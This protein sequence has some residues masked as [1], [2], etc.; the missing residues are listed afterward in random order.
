MTPEQ[1]Q[2]IKETFASIVEQPTER[3]AGLLRELCA[4]DPE[5]W[6]EV[7]S[8]LSAHDDPKSLIVPDAFGIGA[9]LRAEAVDYSGRIFGP[10]RIVRE[11]GR[12]GMGAV[13]L[14]ERAD[15]EFRRQVAL[16]IV[17]HSLAGQEIDRRFRRE[18]Q[19]LAS[20]SHPHIA[21]LLD[22]GVSAD[23]ESFFVM[24]FV[25]GLRID[26]YCARAQLTP[27]ARLKLFLQVCRA[28]AYAHDQ[29]VIHRDLKP[30]NILV[31]KEGVPKLLDFGIAKLLDVS[32]AGEQTA[33]E[34]RAFTPDY[35]APEQMRGEQ[36]LTPAT[37]VFSLGA[38]LAVLLDPSARRR[39]ASAPA[40]PVVP[41]AEPSAGGEGT[42]ETT[43]QAPL[44]RELRN[45]IA[46]AQR[47]EPERRYPSARELSQDIER[48]LDGRPVVAQPDTLRYRISKF[49]EQRRTMLIASVLVL[50]A[51][52]TGITAA[53]F[54]A[55]MNGRRG[56]SP[57]SGDR[58][59][60]G[61][62]GVAHPLGAVRT[63]AV[64]PLK[65][66]AGASPRPAA[67]NGGSGIS[68]GS[69]MDDQALR[70]GMADSIVTK[71]SQVRQLTV[72][73][74]SATVRFLDQEYDAVAVGRELQVDSVLEGTLLRAGAELRTNL[75]LVDVASG[76]VVWAD[77]L[78]SDLSNV[79]RGQESLANRVSQLLALNASGAP[80][81]GAR[82]PQGSAN[83]AAQDAYLR[84]SLALATSV[85]QVANIFAARDAFEQA[86]R[87]DPD[88]ALAHS[89]LANAY[90]LAG[91]LTLLAPQDSYPKA[92]RAARRALEIAPGIAGAYIALA[93]V[94]ADYNWNW[95]AAEEN[96]KK[97]LDLAPNSAGAHQSYAELLA[98]M[99]R[100]AEAAAHADLAQQL[101]PTR[102]NYVAVRALHYYYE[103]RFDEAVAQC[104]RALARD[105]N[106][107]LAYLY[108]AASHAARG[109]FTSG[110]AAANKAQALTGGAASDLFVAGINYALMNDRAN[111][112][113]VLQRL[114]AM[115]HERYIDPFLFVSIYAYRGDK[116]R[117]FEY[118]ERSYAERSYWMTALKVHPIVNALRGDPRFDEMMRRMKFD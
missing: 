89:G 9:G 117:A 79:L 86:I 112:E 102:T 108:L 59:A 39:S 111:T 69:E 114:R 12:G 1:W 44:N 23:G 27:R 17:R 99:G 85:R 77:S 58:S 61:S 55:T 91:S 35:A 40:P 18:R 25:D 54:Y 68:S 7:E 109:D 45:I 93:E 96:N 36:Q 94:E 22:G 20:L 92:E 53:T 64:L 29:L 74:T 8:L 31:T 87:L 43:R 101:D 32:G 42:K 6:R 98:R 46:M 2:R 67:A 115:S 106:L 28:V 90:S 118:L 81:A 110:L 37:D 71:L 105:E 88:F 48:H 80:T 84:G 63:I 66:L 82:H 51:L 103:H 5:L 56:A 38:L 26:D 11:I 10:Y 4:E 57:A 78:T 97:A 14:A 72:R 15:G 83:L 70:V 116:T 104:L 21:H 65:S 3:R 107:Y 60:A 13:F 75:Q 100:F 30:S 16:K 19:I 24:E 47:P 50:F 95:Q 76:S 73:P 41:E 52:V 34:F 49:V 33:T 62:R 113:K